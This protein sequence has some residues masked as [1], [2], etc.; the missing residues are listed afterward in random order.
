MGGMFFNIEFFGIG[1]DGKPVGP[2]RITYPGHNIEGA[3]A[4]AKRIMP[5]N[6][7]RFGRASSFK[8]Y[9]NGILA[10]VSGSAS[11]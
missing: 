5:M 8:I 11:A 9:A 1:A 7:F 3:I 6:T 4:K 2:D 10:Y